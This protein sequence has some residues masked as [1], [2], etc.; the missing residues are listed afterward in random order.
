M[1]QDITFDGHRLTEH[2]F[3]RVERPVG[4]ATRV[5]TTTIA[6]LDGDVVTDVTLEPL[7]LTAH[8]TLRAR[9]RRRWDTLRREFAALFAAKTRRVLTLPDEEGLWRYATASLVGTVAL[10]LEAPSGFDVEF[11]CHD[12][13]AYGTEC[14]TLMGSGPP[15]DSVTFEVGGT[16][17]AHPVIECESIAYTSTSDRLIQFTDEVGNTMVVELPSIGTYTYTSLAIDCDERVVRVGGEVSA[18]SLASDWFEL[19]PG[20]HTITR[21]KGRA[22]SRPKIRWVERWL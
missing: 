18:L 7:V 5:E 3:V 21:A 6:G 14:Y 9:A 19:E 13:V 17:P 2:C 15:P 12:P 20:S 22:S 1:S 8:C 11:C 10:P 4:P 16:A